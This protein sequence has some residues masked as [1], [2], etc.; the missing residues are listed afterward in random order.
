LGL[1]IFSS[2]QIRDL[3]QQQA[4]LAER[5]SSE[6]AAIAMLAYPETQTLHIKADVQGLAGSVLVDND[7]ST[8]VLVLWNL[9]Q[10]EAGETYQVWLLDA[11]GKRTSGGLF[12][13]VD[14]QGYTTATIQSPV[15]IGEFDG[16]GVTVEPEGGSPGPTGPRV[17]A[18]DL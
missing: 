5:F 2:V 12:T 10:L 7:K 16:L 3:Q 1:N 17:L 4:A 14:K 13:P 9:P 11:D 6:Q 15:P 8:A 18:V